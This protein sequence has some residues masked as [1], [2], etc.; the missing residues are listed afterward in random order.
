[1]EELKL[2]NNIRKIIDQFVGNLKNIYGDGLISVTLYGSAA[3]GEFAGRNSN[4]NLAIVLNDTSIRSLKKAGRLA[5]SGK[6]SLIS[7]FFFTEEYIAKSID[8]FPIEFLDIKENHFILHGKDVFGNLQID[9]KNLRFQCEQEL[10]SK[11]INIKKMYLR[12]RGKFFLRELL[13]KS[14]TSS[15]HIMR[16]L[17]RLKGKIP[18]YKKEYIPDEI[19]REFMVDCSGL[20]KILDAKSKKV[21]LNAEEIDDLFDQLVNTLER[22]TDKLDRL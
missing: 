21:R 20:K 16:N 18:P 15:L 6:F 13:F 19:S 4:V 14:A 2:P 11:I 9:L 17:I 3:S 1:M 7:P 5:I 12:T 22:V 8:V 10:K